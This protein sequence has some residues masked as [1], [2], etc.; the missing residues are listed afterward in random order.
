MKIIRRILF[1]IFLSL[2]SSSVWAVS[3]FLRLNVNGSVEASPCSINNG[4]T[5]D[6]DFNDVYIDKIKDEYYKRKIDYNINCKS[7]GN[8][9]F[10]M[11]ILGE[12][13]GYYLKTNN[14][15]LLIAF[16][17][18]NKSFNMGSGIIVNYK[19]QPEIYAILTKKKGTNLRSGK[20]YV[21]ATMQL[22]YL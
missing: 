6:V 15:N 19:K 18:G 8:P 3:G 2:L 10:L 9:E 4:Q 14:D 17:N 16:K 1:F 12:R 22:I 13:E 21:Y 5:I 7:S 11:S 20:F